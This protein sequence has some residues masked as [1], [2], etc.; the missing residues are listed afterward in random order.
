MSIARDEAE[1]IG[2]MK[3]V[4]IQDGR[5]DSGSAFCAKNTALRAPTLLSLKI[6]VETQAYN[7]YGNPN[8]YD[9]GYVGCR[10]KVWKEEKLCVQ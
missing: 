4:D 3:N 2:F 5:S 9:D 6:T 8:P 10:N 7:M 1:A